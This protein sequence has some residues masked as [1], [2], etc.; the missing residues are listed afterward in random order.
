M[1]DNGAAHCWHKLQSFKWFK[2][3]G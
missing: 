1:H 3:K 2:W